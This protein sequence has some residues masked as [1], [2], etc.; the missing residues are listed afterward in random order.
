MV[1]EKEREENS[2]T[3]IR[4]LKESPEALDPETIQ[5]LSGVLDDAWRVVKANLAA[6]RID[7]NAGAVRE[8]LA[9]QIVEFAKYGERDP[10]RLIALSLA[11]LRPNRPP[12][13][14]E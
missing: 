2:S 8:T 13:R 6:F 1:N 4:Y 9:K 12:P 5:L 11:R 7:G 10:Q 3:M 14:T